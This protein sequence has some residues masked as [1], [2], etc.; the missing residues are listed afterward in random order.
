MMA[1]SLASDSR[2]VHIEIV[3]RANRLSGP[4]LSPDRDSPLTFSLENHM[5]IEP[6]IYDPAI[7]W[8]YE[9]CH[10]D[11]TNSD[12]DKLHFEWG[13]ANKPDWHAPT[14]TLISRHGG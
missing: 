5:K 13:S 1:N 12:G 7:H 4:S 10:F 9:H 2:I 8:I 14:I 11:Y 3:N 6:I